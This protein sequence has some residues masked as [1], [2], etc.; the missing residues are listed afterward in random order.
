MSQREPSKLFGKRPPMAAP[1]PGLWS[2][3]KKSVGCDWREVDPDV[4]R[5]SLAACL[6]SGGAMMFSAASGGLGVCVTVFLGKG[7]HKEYAMSGDALVELL[8]EVIDHTASAS[9]DVRMA[10]GLAA[11]VQTPAD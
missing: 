8:D 4:L 3:R 7:R 1:P 2:G 6:S 11:E 5:A 9:E 10:F